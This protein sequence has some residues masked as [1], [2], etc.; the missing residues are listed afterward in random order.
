MAGG[1]D[2]FGIDFVNFFEARKHSVEEFQV[3]V[4]LIA[5]GLLPAR[6]FAFR[7]SQ[8]SRR[9]QTLHINRDGF[10]PMTV[11][12]EHSGRVLRATAV[13]MK[14]ENY[15]SRLFFSGW[16]NVRERFA[17]DSFDLEFPMLELGRW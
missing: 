7:V 1:E 5:D 6:R 14:D 13:T 12:G 15:G 9:V 10:G 16:R 11:H 8:F 4:L 17:G 3:A 2:A